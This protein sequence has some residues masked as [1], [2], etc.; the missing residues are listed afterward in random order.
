[1]KGFP[2]GQAPH[3][4]HAVDTLFMKPLLTGLLSRQSTNKTSSQAR[5]AARL[6]DLWCH[7]TEPEHIPA[8]LQL[9][10]SIAIER[11]GVTCLITTDGSISRP[12]GL[13]P[14]LGW[15]TIERSTQSIAAFFAD[16]APRL[17]LW[18]GGALMPPLI[19][20]TA[21]R[22]VPMFLLDANAE[23]FQTTVW[24]GEGLSQRRALKLFSTFLA[25]DSEAEAALRKM[26]IESDD[27][28]VAGRMQ[29]GVP[30]LP[31]NEADLNDLSR[32]ISSRPTW[33]AACTRAEELTVILPAHLK[34]SRAAHRLLLILVPDDEDEC[35]AFKQALDEHR[36][37]YSVWPDMSGL[38]DETAQ[39]LLAED[40]FE[41]GLWLRVSPVTFMGASLVSGF[42]GHNPYAA[43]NLGSAILYGPNV[44]KHLLAYSR[45]ASAGGARIV[46]DLDTLTA[47]VS[48]L[49]APDRAAQ[50]AMVAWEIATEGAD[51]TDRVTSLVHDAL[52]HLEES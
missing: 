31:H 29:Q 17:C 40:P 49:S 18:A 46:R 2:H 27:I 13:E 12:E 41:M 33:L 24:R 8:F 42:G 38:A 21:K 39:V 50:M 52:D 30:S 5:P 20:E 43:A 22:G 7:A 51:V 1:M 48:Q 44:G 19:S 4:H 28:F 26:G 25:R 23:S 15:S 37:R 16:W 11:P 32:A 6:V 10:R 35:D 45:F 36:L 9:R 47:A 34:A 14:T 3:I